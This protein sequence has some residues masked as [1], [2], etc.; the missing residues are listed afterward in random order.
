MVVPSQPTQQ[1]FRTFPQGTA[2]QG[3]YGAPPIQGR[4]A[5]TQ[6]LQQG[7]GQAYMSNTMHSSGPRVP[8]HQVHAEPS[9]LEAAISSQQAP[10][11]GRENMPPRSVEDCRKDYPSWVH[12]KIPAGPLVHHEPPRR[13]QG[14]SPPPEDSGEYQ[15]HWQDLV[16]QLT[17]RQDPER[18]R[19]VEVEP[20]VWA[21]PDPRVVPK[22]S[23]KPTPN[24]KPP[25]QKKEPT[26]P[27]GP[28][29]APP[30]APPQEAASSS[31]QQ[32]PQKRKRRATSSDSRPPGQR[33]T[34][35]LPCSEIPCDNYTE[36]HDCSYCAVHCDDPSCKVHGSKRTGICLG[37]YGC[38]A[39]RPLFGCVNYACGKCCLKQEQ[40]QKAAGVENINY[41]RYHE[42]KREKQDSGFP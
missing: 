23:K 16:E 27:G 17:R 7:C 21:V 28:P 24:E 31:D 1:S 9:S 32:P 34:T 19:P 39:I 30:P 8:C 36:S 6:S 4:T 25:P 33:Q 38:K 42:L 12:Y 3:L 26:P 41:C 20:P 2:P 40:L 13:R 14:S 15:P 11:R 5:E 35:G 10:K 18:P 22:P 29:P 37:P